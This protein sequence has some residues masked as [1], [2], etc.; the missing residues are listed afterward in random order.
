MYL[1]GGDFGYN[2]STTAI[3]PMFGC[4][5]LGDGSSTNNVQLVNGEAG[6]FAEGMTL[7]YLY[8]EGPDSYVDIIGPSGGTIFFRSQ[9]NNGRAIWYNGPGGNYRAVHSSCIF[10]A[11]RD[12]AN[13]KTGLMADYMDYLTELI[14]VQE[15]VN[16]SV[17]NLSLFPNPT[18]GRS[19]INFG[20]TA[21][22]KLVIKVYNTAGQLVSNLFDAELTRGTHSVVWDGKDYN[23]RKVSNGTYM[24]R[25][26]LDDQ[27]TQKAIVLVN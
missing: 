21:P 4:S 8:G 12:G 23:G 13:T 2:N 22:G 3:Y 18:T 27:V 7:D 9:D 20:I 5:Y 15:L 25:I 24:L 14:G 6:T 17:R 16:A 19:T 26:E 10:G 11:L 1:E